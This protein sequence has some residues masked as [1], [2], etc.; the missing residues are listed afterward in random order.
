MKIRPVGTELF[1]ADGRTDGRSE[2]LQ[3]VERLVE[4]RVR[5][6]KT[7]RERE[8]RR[9]KF[10]MSPSLFCVLLWLAVKAN[11]FSHITSR[12]QISIPHVY[13]M[14]YRTVPNAI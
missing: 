9:K 11:H 8:R 10:E 3:G 1:H 13:C 4:Y 6:Q 12:C 2:K 14:P 5:V 7:E